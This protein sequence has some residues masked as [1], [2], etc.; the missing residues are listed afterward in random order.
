[1]GRLHAIVSTC[2]LLFT[3]LTALRL[4]ESDPQTKNLKGFYSAHFDYMNTPPI[5]LFDFDTSTHPMHF[6]PF[7]PSDILHNG[8]TDAPLHWPAWLTDNAF[9]YP[10]KT[11]ESSLE[12]FTAWAYASDPPMGFMLLINQ[13][14]TRWWG[15][16][17]A[18]RTYNQ[19]GKLPG[20]VKDQKISLGAN[21]ALTCIL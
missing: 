18:T 7:A 12:S 19:L 5:E 15:L 17:V 2:S 1:M 10:R 16:G 14:W 11:K 8:Q 20:D 13:H 6:I 4:R 3:C 21:V 9:I